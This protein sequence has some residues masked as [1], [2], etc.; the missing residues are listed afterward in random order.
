MVLFSYKQLQHSELNPFSNCYLRKD[1]PKNVA[2][3]KIR[4]IYVKSSDDLKIPII[5]FD[6]VV[7]NRYVFYDL[8]LKKK[9]H[10]IIEGRERETDETI[11]QIYQ[12]VE[13]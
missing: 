7:K 1:L 6:F 9:N 8:S 10:G 11:Y 3:L 13:K 4:T 5:P 2:L 12:T